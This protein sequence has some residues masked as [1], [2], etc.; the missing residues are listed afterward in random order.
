MIELSKQYSLTPYT[1]HEVDD[2][3]CKNKAYQPVTD[4]ASKLQDEDVKNIAL[5]GPFGS[6]KSSVLLTLQKDFKQYNYLNIS[7]ATLECNNETEEDVYKNKTSAADINTE[8]TQITSKEKAKNSTSISSQSKE[9]ALN[10]LIEYSIL[11]QLIYREKASKIPQ[12]RFKRIKHISNKESFC[13]SIM[14]ILVVITFFILFEPEF[15]RIESIYNLLSCSPRWKLFWDTLSL[16]YFIAAII[17]AVKSL[18]TKTYNSKINKINLKD[19]EIDISESTSIFNKHLDEIIYFF[20]VTNY[21]V[22]IIEDLDRFN[23]SNIYLKLR[24]LNNLLNN[25][26]AIKRKNGRQIVFI[27]AVRDDIFKDTSR[28]KFFDYISTVIPIINPSNSCD[29]LKLALIEHEIT[30]VSD[31]VCKDLGVFIDDMRIL[32]NIVNEFVQYRS[33]LDINRLDSKKLFA[34][35]LYKNYYP[36]DFASL[37]NQ[38]GIVCDIIKN[39]T[40]YQQSAV[41]EKEKRIS[42]LQE[43]LKQIADFYSTQVAKEVRALYV[44]E[45]VIRLALIY[46]NENGNLYT[47]SQIINDKNLFDKLMKNEFSHYNNSYSSYVLNLKFQEIEK[48]V[49]SSKGYLERLS[50]TP[51]RVKEIKEEIGKIQQEI[52][53]YKSIPLS[54]L[55]S[56]YSADDF[57]KDVKENHLIAFLLRLGYI[58]EYYYDYISYFYEGTMTSSDREFVLDV[59]IG[60]SKDYNYD[61]HRPKAV[62]D[63]IPNLAF[64]NGVVLNISLV[65][66]IVV[67]KEIYNTQWTW[68]KKFIIR[69]KEFGFIESYY[70]GAKELSMFFCDILPSWNMFFMEG[71]LKINNPSKEDI[72]FEI[73]LRYFPKAE[74]N[75]YNNNFF[76]EYLSGMFNFISSKLGIV[77]LENIKFLTSEFEIKYMSLSTKGEVPDTLIQYVINGNYY[78]LNRENIITILSLTNIFLIN[79]FVDASYSTIIE[80]KNEGLINYVTEN[81]QDCIE[82]V[83]SNKSTQE[84]EIAIIAIIENENIE[85]SIKTSYL[86]LQVTKIKDLESISQENWDIAVKSN[87]IFATWK[88][89]EKYILFDIEKD[90]PLELTEFI[91][92]NSYEL[93]KQKTGGILEERSIHKLFSTLIGRNDLPIT[94]Y[95]LIREAFN[96]CFTKLNLSVLDSEKLNYLIET[97]GIEF[98][99]YHYTLLNDHFMD[100]APKFLLHNKNKYLADIDSYPLSERTAITLLNSTQLRDEEKLIITKS[101]PVKTISE[102]VKLANIICQQLNQ[103]KNCVVS[104]DCILAVMY[105]CNEQNQKLSL[106]VKKCLESTY[107]AAF[108]KSGLKLLDGDYAIIALQKGHRPKLTITDTHT[109][110]VEYLEK[111]GLISK[112]NEEKNMIRVNCKN[113][114]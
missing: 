54:G 105:G 106:F 113:I 6:G 55:L 13:V 20:E 109:A 86:S 16:L 50:M 111:G 11:Q 52:L 48:T 8:N 89:V 3:G 66:F 67:N 102:N 110:L 61:I 4:I 104:N 101:L 28:T 9:E 83:F 27:Y 46:F 35:I 70:L 58:D 19:G 2:K 17:Y 43:E 82:G 91:T 72:N 79:R 73:L 18:I 42:L 47:P 40:K 95:R 32:K 25:S 14:F 49:G 93:S 63:Q 92:N 22:V 30:D 39:K 1:I 45:Y 10:R 81:L 21:D 33:K 98:N 114:G 78:M 99:E 34:M 75:Q 80:S 103:T 56:K 84:S 7:L 15:L 62:I 23:T 38:E 36:K 51:N 64:I 100:L 41:F 97:R 108:V 24:E 87:I 12:S 29:K 76:I 88:N 53:E 96:L 85:V 107:D 94:S 90:L 71:V 5:T 68:I 31:D 77:G 37:H 60:R 65:N 26:E 59:K 44:L 69:K 74:I 112:H 57:F